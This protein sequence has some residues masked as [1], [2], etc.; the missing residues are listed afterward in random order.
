MS[1]AIILK[2][3]KKAPKVYMMY[4]RPKKGGKTRNNTLTSLTAQ[5]IYEVK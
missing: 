3:P 2:A 1:K 5:P 4:T